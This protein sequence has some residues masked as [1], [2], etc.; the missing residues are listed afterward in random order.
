MIPMKISISP[1]AFQLMSTSLCAN[2]RARYQPL[3]RGLAKGERRERKKEKKEERKKNNIS[4]RLWRR[5]GR[6]WC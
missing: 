5:R 6:V 2:A 3:W 1:F 4:W